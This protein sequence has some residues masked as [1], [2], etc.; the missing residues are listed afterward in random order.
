MTDHFRF[1][2]GEL[3][4]KPDEFW[5]LTFSEFIQMAEGYTRRQKREINNYIAGAWYSAILARQKQIPKLNSLL[6]EESAKKQQTDDEMLTMA[7]LLNAAFG[8]EVIEV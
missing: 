2:V 8:G 3:N 6:Q 1:G 7:K 5:G 4:L